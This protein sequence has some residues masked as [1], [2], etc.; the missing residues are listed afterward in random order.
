MLHGLHHH[1][2]NLLNRSRT[3]KR[4]LQYDADM[5]EAVEADD[6]IDEATAYAVL[7]TELALADGSMDRDEERVIEI[8]LGQIPGVRRGDVGM[9]MERARGMIDSFRGPFSFVSRIKR[10]YSH[11]EREKLFGMIDRLI[12]AD[13]VENGYEKYLREKFH[14]LLQ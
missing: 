1:L 13:G 9:L 5:L 2:S 11:A 8:A 7:L 6:P 14:A 3:H 4:L 12:K 10:E